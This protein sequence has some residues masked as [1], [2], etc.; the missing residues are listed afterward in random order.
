MLPWVIM[1][2]SVSLDG[3]II[4]LNADSNLYYEL[5][6][7]LDFDAVLMDSN[8][9]LTGFN[10]Q[11]GELRGEDEVINYNQVDPED[12]RPILVVPDSKGH[13]RIWNE[14]FKMPSVKDILVLCSRSTP[15]EYLDFLDEQLMKYM[16]VGYQQVDLE[17]A[18][19]ELNQQFDVKSVWVDSGGTLNG[20]L[21]KQGL[22]DEVHVLLHPVLAVGSSSSSIYQTQDLNSEGV[23]KLKLQKINKLKE[24]I[25][26]LQ[27]EILK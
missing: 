14:V 4:G 3:R 26:W 23:I 7:K 6:S 20:I 15:Q 18:L 11:L 1:Y 19:D 27:Y 21:L 9:L 5:A 12:Q 13:I 16:I 22:V 2:N 10:A 25:V 17:T 8:T 24:D